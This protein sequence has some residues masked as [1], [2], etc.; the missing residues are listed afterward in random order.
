MGY[1]ISHIQTVMIM[2]SHIRQPLEVRKEVVSDMKQTEVHALII[3]RNAA[4]WSFL[5]PAVPKYAAAV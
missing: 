5:E 3:G 2:L 4:F 1:N